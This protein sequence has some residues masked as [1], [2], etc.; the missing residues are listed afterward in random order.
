MTGP[1][2]PFCGCDPYEY[3]DVG[4]GG[5]GQPVAVTCCELGIDFFDIRHEKD[6]VEISRG[7]FEQ[8]AQIFN[9]MRRLGLTPDIEA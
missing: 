3:V 9:A 4:V 2:C 7:H 6:T 1:Q 8:I 5:R